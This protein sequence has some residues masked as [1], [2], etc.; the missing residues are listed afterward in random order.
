MSVI[1]K[2]LFFLSA[3]PAS[4]FFVPKKSEKVERPRARRR[5]GD[6]VALGAMLML[7]SLRSGPQEPPRGWPTVTLGIEVSL[8]DGAVFYIPGVGD[9]E[10]PGIIPLPKSRFAG[11]RITPRMGTDSVQIEVSALTKTTEKLSEA[12]CDKVQSWNSE[13]AGS[14][15]G[16][17]DAS[18]LLSGLGRLGLPVLKVKVVRAA[19]PPPSPSGGF[20]HSYANFLAFCSCNFPEPRSII[21]DGMPARGV[22]GILS[23]PDAGKCREVSG[24]GQCCRTVV[25]TSGQKAVR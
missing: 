10:M 5:C 19:G 12:T 3:F 25:P 18:L 9:G 14:Y 20:N 8:P 22:A 21:S 23:Y 2:V 1:R 17:K 16:K 11:I 15:M 13:D 24:C 4:L 7:G 6:V